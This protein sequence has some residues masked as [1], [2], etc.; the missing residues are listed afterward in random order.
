MNDSIETKVKGKPG[1]KP[2][3]QSAAG[4]TIFEAQR[5]GL[6]KDDSRDPNKRVEAER[7]RIPFGAGQDQWLNGYHLDWDNYHYHEF[8]ESATRGGRIAE[9]DRAFYEHCQINGENI[10]RPSGNGWSYLMRIPQKYYQEDMANAR[11][12]H[13]AIEKD[14]NTLKS[15][16]GIQD[17]AVDVKSGRPVLEGSADVAKHSV[18]ENPYA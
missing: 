7:V 14:M 6:T 17:Y 10:K 8:H 12:R 5:E 3:E 18:S 2:R 9:A 16:D 13:K 11:K 4:L 1:P 15:K